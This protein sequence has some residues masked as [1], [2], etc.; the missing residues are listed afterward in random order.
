[1]AVSLK[2]CIS[3]YVGKAKMRLRG[4]SFFKFSKICLHFSAVCLQFFKSIIAYQ[5]HFGFTN[6]GSEMHSFRDTAIWNNGF[7]FGSPC[8][9][10][11]V[12]RRRDNLSQ[13]LPHIGKVE[14]GPP[15]GKYPKTYTFYRSTLLLVRCYVEVLYGRHLLRVKKLFLLWKRAKFIIF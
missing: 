8:T 4:G 10:L 2:L 1:M 9:I 13:F 11:Q 12:V 7:L 6:I 15:F 14:D 5:T 3:D